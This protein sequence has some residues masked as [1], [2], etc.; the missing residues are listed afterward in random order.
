MMRILLFGKNGQLGWELCRSLAPLGPVEACDL[1]VMEIGNLVD[2]TDPDDL[3]RVI[4]TCQPQVIVNAA[5]YTAVDKAESEAEIAMA[6]NGVAPGIIAEEAA[7]SGAAL[8]HYSTDYV[9]DGTKGSAY[10][11]SDVPAPLNVYG[12]SK[13]AGEQAIIQVDGSYL[14]L[15][16]SWVYSLRRDS[17]VTKV[18][19]WSREQPVLRIVSDQVGNPTWSRMLAEAT[20]HLVAM[21]GSHLSEWIDARKGIYHLAGNGC[22]SRF[23]WA[24]EI[25]RL[26]IARKGQ[27]NAETWLQC[28]LQPALTSEF[29]TPARRPLF[30]AL[31]CQLFAQTFGL[32]LPD[33]QIGLQLAMETIHE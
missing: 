33:W 29:P 5:A 27:D 23:E 4:R 31:N 28:E 3:R 24:Q 26:E 10:L 18:L 1:Q 14:I 8:I 20:S 16:T 15:R 25:L 12:R 21:G 2:F 19:K 22:A 30:S 17:F 11:E 32:C 9:F 7:S 6:V 13:L